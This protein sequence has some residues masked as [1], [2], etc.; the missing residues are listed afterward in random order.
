MVK[1]WKAIIRV[2]QSQVRGQLTWLLGGES[3]QIIGQK[4]R[5]PWVEILITQLNEGMCGQLLS[6]G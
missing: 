2:K 4:E 3:T 6:H 5:L 1:G